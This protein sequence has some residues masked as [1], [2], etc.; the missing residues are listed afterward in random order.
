MFVRLNK[1]LNE[2]T[3]QLKVELKPYNLRPIELYILAALYKVDGQR[4]NQLAAAVGRV[5]TAFTP[6]LDDLESKGYIERR[7]SK[8]DRRSTFIYLSQGAL[9]VRENL[10]AILEKYADA[11]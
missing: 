8:D 1:Q 5:A 6:L 11:D 3:Q 2:L 7:T 10:E 4:A 9:Q